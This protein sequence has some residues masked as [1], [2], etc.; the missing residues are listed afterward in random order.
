VLE[1]NNGSF[2]G[3]TIVRGLR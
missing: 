1:T 3:F 2:Y